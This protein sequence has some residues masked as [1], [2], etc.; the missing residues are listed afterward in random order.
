MKRK[1]I[2]SGLAAL[3]SYSSANGDIRS[4]SPS[5][6]GGCFGPT[7]PSMPS[8]IGNF[9]SFGNFGSAI[10]GGSGLTAPLPYPRTCRPG[11]PFC[12]LSPFPGRIEDIARMMGQEP[13]TVVY[14]PNSEDKRINIPVEYVSSLYG[15]AMRLW[16]HNRDKEFIVLKEKDG[17]FE[18]VGGTLMPISSKNSE[19]L[20]GN[21]VQFLDDNF[22][23]E[24]FILGDNRKFTSKARLVKISRENSKPSLRRLNY[25]NTNFYIEEIIKHESTY[26]PTNNFLHIDYDNGNIAARYVEK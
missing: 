23:I 2:A 7:I 13:E 12:D 5:S 18:Y 3:I 26:T 16:L 9:G 6:R 21:Y 14:A 10:Y 22:N 4:S 25:A 19:E 15:E 1:I 8:S 11:D 24:K 17:K 20:D